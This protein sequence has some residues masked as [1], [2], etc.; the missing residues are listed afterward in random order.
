MF[1]NNVPPMPP[2]ATHTHIRRR[3]TSTFANAI[4]S[5]VSTCQWPDEKNIR[6]P[7]KKSKASGGPAGHYQT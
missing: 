3:A 2:L 5:A 7:K 4:A 1:A 6:P